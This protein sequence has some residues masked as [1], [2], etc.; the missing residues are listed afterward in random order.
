MA[1]AAATAA[2]WQVLTLIE[3][4]ARGSTVKGGWCGNGNK[5]CCLPKHKP[6]ASN[7]NPKQQITETTIR[8]EGCPASPLGN[9]KLPVER[10]RGRGRVG[11]GVAAL[12]AGEAAL[13][14]LFAAP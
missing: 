1:T 3:Q 4:A 8:I 2:A 5:F 11:E 12:E 14:G 7:T 6:L 13:S 10:G 9:R